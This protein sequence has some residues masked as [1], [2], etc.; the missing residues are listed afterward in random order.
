MRAQYVLTVL[1]FALKFKT[2]IQQAFSMTLAFFLL[3][4][5][6]LLLAS[7]TA[8]CDLIQRPFKKQ[9]VERWQAALQSLVFTP[10]VIVDLVAGIIAM[11]TSDHFRTEHGSDHC[12]N[13]A[14]RHKLIITG[15]RELEL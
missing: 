13:H 6:I 12:D 10:L 5:I 1:P 7:A 3:Y 14:V 15:Y 4:P 2:L 11:G 8:L 9:N